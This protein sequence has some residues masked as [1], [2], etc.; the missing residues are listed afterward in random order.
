MKKKAVAIMCGGASYEHEVSIISGIQIA[1]HIDRTRYEPYFVY[2]D[3]KNNAFLIKNFTTKKDFFTKKRLPVTLTKRGDSVVLQTTSMWS[4]D[5]VIDVVYL[6]FHGGTGESGPVQGMLETLNVP[7]TGATQEGSVLAMNKVITKEVLA[8]H[9]IPVLPWVSVLSADFENDKSTTLATITQQL[10]FPIIIKPA[11]L[12]SSIGITI[13]HNEIELEQQLA[14]ACRIDAEMLLE[15]ALADFVEYNI[16]VRSN[17][18]ELVCSPIEEPK[19]EGEV[20]SFDDKYVNGGKKN[21]GTKNAAG[22]ESLDRTVPADISDELATQIQTTAK[23]IY[24]ACR[25]SGML[26]IDFMY[27]N[28]QLYCTEPNPIPGSLAFYLW[29]AAGQS[30][31][32]QISIDIEDAL[33]RHAAAIEIEP[34]ETDIVESFIYA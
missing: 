11:H 19:R 34:Y 16:A 2:F 26:R 24:T 13:V 22:M 27:S 32:E 17:Q 18:G 20:L 33:A 12:G 23:Q 21:G 14:L 6:A 29:E 15:P 28:G 8:A 5:V 7:H 1:T 30:F 4:S 10:N 25:L 31:A 3:K 9:D